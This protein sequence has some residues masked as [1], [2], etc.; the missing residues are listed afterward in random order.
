MILQNSFNFYAKM[1]EN[2]AA[3][4]IKKINFQLVKLIDGRQL[5]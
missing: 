1:L 5:K 4:Y 3:T 2:T